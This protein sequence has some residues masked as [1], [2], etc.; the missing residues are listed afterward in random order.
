MDNKKF[1]GLHCQ[2]CLCF[3]SIKAFNTKKFIYIK[4]EC[5]VTLTYKLRSNNSI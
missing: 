3:N 2:Y 5:F 4:T 1:M